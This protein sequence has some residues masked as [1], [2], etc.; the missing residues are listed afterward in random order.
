MRP[1]RTAPSALVPHGSPLPQGRHRGARG[2]AAWLT[3]AWV[4]A[5]GACSQVPV[6]QETERTELP[7][8]IEHSYDKNSVM[9]STRPADARVV[10]MDT[11]IPFDLPLRY[12]H[13]EP[14]VRVELALPLVQQG[15]V[16]LAS[17]EDLRRL[18]APWFGVKTDPASGAIDIV[19]H[20]FD[21]QVV[22]GQGSRAPTIQ[23]GRQV[24]RLSLTLG[25]GQA[26]VETVSHERVNRV[27]DIDAAP[28]RPGSTQRQALQW[29]VAPRVIGGRVYLPVASVMQALG[30]TITTDAAAGWLAVSDVGPAQTDSDLFNPRYAAG[31]GYAPLS[32]SRIAHMRG[33]L[34]GTRREGNF[35]FGL[36]FDSID[37][38][39]GAFE[40]DGRGRRVRAKVDRI[41]PYRLYV[42]KGHDAT[43]PAKLAYVLHGATGNENAA[44]ERFNDHLVNQP[45]PLPDVVT[46]EDHAD[47]YGYLLLSPNGWTRNPQWG[48]GPAEVMAE[49]SLADV[50]RRLAVDPQR[51]FL[52]GNSAGGSGVM[53]YAARHPGVFRA[54]AP[55]APAPNRPAGDALRGPL[56]DM[57]TLMACF[58]ADVTIYYMGERNFACQPWY[59]ADVRS[60]MRDLTF[61]TVE[62]GHH[63]HGPASLLQ[64]TF[65]FFEDVLAGR[66]DRPTGTVAL[67]AGRATARIVDG[68]RAGE[69]IA[70]AQA[71]VLRGTTLMVGLADLSRIYG[72]QQFR[73]YR[74]HAYNRQPQDLVSVVTVNYRRTSV[75]LRAGSDFLRVGGTVKAGDSRGLT[76]TVPADD[77]RVDN[78]RLS[79]ASFE[80]A[81]DLWLPA[82]ELMTIFGQKIV[83]E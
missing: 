20:R 26:Q 49:A 40:P 52:T 25:Q 68:P 42:P 7:G 31:H 80:Q 62:N 83:I 15:G 78:R 60:R 47:R 36:Y 27:A 44:F 59:E 18:Y 82:A 8:F 56:L 51:L 53:N 9:F 76:A 2:L 54:L 30:K 65:D 23:Y 19:H 46:V 16:L 21:R 57:P 45:S 79:V 12:R 35:W 69:V 73:A 13:A 10:F 48:R 55:T 77:A 63:S 34:D 50:K 37:T 1:C 72:A 14:L 5:L 64:M 6:L 3:L 11:I 32:P 43:R 71:P 24:Y 28:V 74:V 67:A 39:S 70:L 38:F 4:L 75:N 29:P 58:S 66:S 33:V 81:G 61:V 22:G 41:L 17:L